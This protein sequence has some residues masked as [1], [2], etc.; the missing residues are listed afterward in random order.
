MNSPL[1]F[2]FDIEPGLTSSDIEQLW[3]Q[4]QEAQNALDKFLAGEFTEQEMTDLLTLCKIDLDQTRK[5][6]D[7]N[8]QT[9]GMIA[10]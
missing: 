7:Q 8:A 3:N 10:Y 4:T 5:L 2:A 1:I 6:L 9:L